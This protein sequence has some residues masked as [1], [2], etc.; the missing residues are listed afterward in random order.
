MRNLL[1]LAVLVGLAWCAVGV[2]TSLGTFGTIPDPPN[3]P[4]DPALTHRY[5]VL[6][7]TDNNGSTGCS[8]YVSDDN[9]TGP[10]TGIEKIVSIYVTGG[11]VITN[12]VSS[13]VALE[14]VNLDPPAP[15]IQV[16]GVYVQSCTSAPG[17]FGTPTLVDAGPWNVGLNLGTA[18]DGSNADVV[19]GYVPRSMLGGNGPL[20]LYY[21]VSAPPGFATDVVPSTDGSQ[22]GASIILNDDNLAG[23]PTLA[24]WGRLAFA[25]AV[26]VLTVWA[27]R[28]RLAP[29]V[30]AA[31]FVVVTLGAAAVAWATTIAMD[32]NPADWEGSQAVVATDQLCDQTNKCAPG[33]DVV[34][35]FSTLDATNVYFRFDLV[36]LQGLIDDCPSNCGTT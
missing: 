28:R 31:V 17:T 3:P 13:G 5:R 2:G 33:E 8:I 25:L 9:F 22:N 10:I 12:P 4:I 26:G 23:I 21:W 24:S 30:L 35:T 16:I 36:D 11:Q 1:R 20:R 32:G 15:A 19:E 29:G 6:V 18:F 14:T 34:T 27:F 7:D